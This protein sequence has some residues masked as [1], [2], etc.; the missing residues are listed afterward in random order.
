MLPVGVRFTGQARTAGWSSAVPL[1]LACR[2]LDT[3]T[4]KLVRLAVKASAY[5]VYAW[6]IHWLE[7]R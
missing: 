5:G 4:D 7:S 6:F 1:R 3:A 2:L